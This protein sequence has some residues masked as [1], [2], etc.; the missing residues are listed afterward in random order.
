MKRNSEVS[1]TLTDAARADSVPEE[2]ARRIVAYGGP[3]H[4]WTAEEVEWLARHQD[5]LRFGWLL[6]SIQADPAAKL[7]PKKEADD[8]D[9]FVS[10]FPQSS[11]ITEEKPPRGA[12]RK[13][14][15]EVAPGATA[16]LVSRQ[17]WEVALKGRA[18][19]RLEWV[20]SMAIAGYKTDWR[21]AF[22]LRAMDL[23]TLGAEQVRKCGAEGCGRLFFAVKRQAFCSKRCSLRERQHRFREQFTEAQWRKRRKTEYLK[24]LAKTRL[25]QRGTNKAG[26][27]S[28]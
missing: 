7:D 26:E 27:K 13:L 14:L 11:P 24:G 4:N 8:F 10:G 18:S 15:R 22:L 5:N 23:L 1:K 6:D 17:P 21:S 19:R 12:L 20:G 25:G 9:W 3:N 2:R 16:F 28:L